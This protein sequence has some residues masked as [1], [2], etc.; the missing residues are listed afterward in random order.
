MAEQFKAKLDA[1]AAAVAEAGEQAAL[2]Q[3]ELM[4][5]A[6][7]DIEARVEAVSKREQV[8]T[9]A[10]MLCDRVGPA[11]CSSP[12][13]IPAHT[14]AA[15]AVSKTSASLARE[16]SFMEA[17][18]GVWKAGVCKLNVGGTLFTTTRTTLMADPTSMLAAMFSGRHVLQEM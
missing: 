16:K 8:R 5:A 10:R 11:R 17:Q 15:Q 2:Q 4:A 12:S 14:H 6:L 7:G 18:E 9:R 1:A 13:H 3:Q